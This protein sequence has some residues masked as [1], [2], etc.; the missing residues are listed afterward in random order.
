[1]RSVPPRG[2]GSPARQPGWDSGCGWVRCIMLNQP[3]FLSRTHPLPRGGTDLIGLI[4][5]PRE[6]TQIASVQI[7][8]IL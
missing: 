8:V 5:V 7:G 3:Q 2:P 6:S 4:V 1:M